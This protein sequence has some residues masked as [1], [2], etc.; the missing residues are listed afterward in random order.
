MVEAG[1]AITLDD[2]EIGA[3]RI[4]IPPEGWRVDQILTLPYFGLETTRDTK[5]AQMID[6]YTRLVASAA[7][8]EEVERLAAKLA[9]RA[10]APQESAEAREAFQLINEFYA[11]KLKKLDPKRREKILREVQVQLAESIAGSRRP[12]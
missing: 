4:D 9:V 11:D 6:D 2:V 3:E 8:A 7:P 12:L 5:T 1:E 10:P